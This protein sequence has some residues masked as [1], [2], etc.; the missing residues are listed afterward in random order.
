MPDWGKEGEEPDAK[1]RDEGSAKEAVY[2]DSKD[3]PAARELD[4]A[5]EKRGL[6]KIGVVGGGA[7]DKTLD[8]WLAEEEGSTEEEE[9]ETESGSEEEGSEEEGSESED[10]EEVDRLVK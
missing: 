2:G 6:G 4:R 9:E 5:V 8:D 1:L 10:D 3:V 7:K